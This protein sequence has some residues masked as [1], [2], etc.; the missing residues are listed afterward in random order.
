MLAA[1]LVV[2]LLL[3]A[4]IVFVRAQ[5]VKNAP[6]PIIAP[7]ISNQ[8]FS[9]DAFK[10]ERRAATLTVGLRAT[11]TAS[12][13]ILDSDDHQIALA[14]TQQT[15]RRIRATWDGALP[16]GG[17]AA[18]G[19]Y[20]FAIELQHE[21][22]SIRI[23][24]ALRLDATPPEVSSTAKA[25]QRIT[26]GVAGGMGVYSF[27]LSANEPVRL[28]LVVRQVQTDGTARLIRRESGLKWTQRKLM[29]WPADKGGQPLTTTGPF[30]G[31]G[32][33]IV[34][35]QA[36]DRGGNRIDAPAVVDSGQLA[37]ARVVGV[38][39]VAL[40]PSLQPV[41][42]L[43]DVQLVRHE[44]GMSFPGRVVGQAKGAPGA[45]ALPRPK[46]GLYAVTIAGGGWQG[47]APEGVAGQ[48][49]TL[50]L[51]PLYSWQAVNPADA[52]LSGF[53]DLPPQPL[54]LNRPFDPSITTPLAALARAAAAVHAG[55]GG[56]VGAVS[57]QFIEDHGVPAAARIVV[58][59]RASVWTDGLFQRL[60]AFVA[61]GGQVLLLDDASLQQRAI[62]SASAI[63]LDRH[64]APP[65]AQLA[66]LRAISDATARPKPLR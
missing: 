32:S 65:I 53:P 33:Y 4:G 38:E 22:R 19:S 3:G 13:V 54:A 66:P 43:S 47:W 61:R 46:P 17:R 28:R 16:G 29:Q 59:S 49:R 30:V 10:P 35:W 36:E 44:P 42:L 55:L 34:G 56:R 7:T 20:R 50:M 25:G 58:I 57:D 45:V 63:T 14:K 41:T 60:R 9:P 62:R 64:V 2:V 27:T 51:L 11:G 8:T 24:D 48:A 12:V 1:L 21:H 6:S 31:P 26:P 39:T 52:D 40:Q 18:D 15:G 5:L 23:P 37:P